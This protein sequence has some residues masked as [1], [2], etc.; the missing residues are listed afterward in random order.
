MTNY[1]YN[2]LN[3]HDIANKIIER[4]EAYLLTDIDS[5][6]F[7]EKCR[8]ALHHNKSFHPFSQQLDV[9][10]LTASIY[11][12][13]VRRAD[14]DGFSLYCMAA[15][16]SPDVPRK[17]TR[18]TYLER[19]IEAN[20]L[21]ARVHQASRDPSK[22]IEQLHTLCAEI[23]LLVALELDVEWHEHLLYLCY[24]MLATYE[25]DEQIKQKA[26]K[27][28]DDLAL[29]LVLDGSYYHLCHLCVKNRIDSKMLEQGKLFD[30][31]T[32]FWKTVSFIVESYFYERGAI[33]LGDIIGLR[34]I[35]GIGCDI[36]VTRAKQIYLYLMFHYP[37][38]RAKLLTIAGVPHDKTSEDLYEAERICRMQIKDNK[39]AN[40]WRLILIALLYGDCAK[41][42]NVYDEIIATGT[43]AA[44]S[45][46]PKAYHMLRQAEAQK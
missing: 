23:E 25:G 7:E 39:V 41:V 42:D 30:D 46:I 29:K 17:D 44:L 24:N 26:K 43:D 18:L 33:H 21:E 9:T 40:Y 2:G 37:Y 19:A 36:D 45:N 16:F 12:E 4:E 1:S 35:R 14:Q 28:A 15:L 8:F 20:S 10:K 5:L 38:D 31:E 3:A 6:T 22:S 13:L 34:L 27:R 32:L 11:P